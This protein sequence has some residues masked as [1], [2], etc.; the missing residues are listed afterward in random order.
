MNASMTHTPVL[1]IDPGSRWTAGVL[2]YGH[3]PVYGWTLGPLGLGGQPDPTAI[4]DL[5]AIGAHG[6]Y[7]AAVVEAAME[8]VERAEKA[9]GSCLVAV[10]GIRVP[11]SHRGG[12]GSRIPVRDWVIPRTTTMALL[13]VFPDAIVI[14]PRGN[15]SRARTD[16]PAELQRRRPSTWGPNRAR[17]GE[18]SHERSAYDVALTAAGLLRTEVA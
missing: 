11:A 8:T 15:G 7:L 9:W 2:T 6:R 12:R 5:N 14:D 10:E 1:G 16:Y 4:D 18:R 13:A 17:K 3:Q